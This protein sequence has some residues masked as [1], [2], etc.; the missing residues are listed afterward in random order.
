[1]TDLLPAKRPGFGCVGRTVKLQANF[2]SFRHA[3]EDIIYKYSVRF[4]PEIPAQMSRLREKIFRKAIASH[5]ANVRFVFSNTILFSFHYSQQEVLNVVYD[6]VPYTL[7]LTIAGV[8]ES[9][10]EQRAF[11]NK[12]FNSVQGR[13]NLFMIGRKFFSMTECIELPHKRVKILNGYSTSVQSLEGGCFVNIDLAHRCL[14][15]V[16]VLEQIEELRTGP[17]FVNRVKSLLIGQSVITKYNNKLYRVDDIDFETRPDSEFTTA[18]GETQSFHDYFAKR[19]HCQLTRMD[20]PMLKC[21]VKQITALLVPELCC[22]TG[23]SEEVRPEVTRATKKAPSA[24]LQATK[25]LIQMIDREPKAKAELQQWKVE[26]LDAPVQLEGRVLPAGDICMGKGRS[27]QINAGSGRFDRDVQSEMYEQVKLNMWGIFYM[28]SDVSLVNTFLGTFQQCLTQVGFNAAAPGRFEIQSQSWAEWKSTLISKLNPSVQLIICVL[29]GPKNKAPLYNDLKRLLLSTYPV[30]S[31][32]ILSATLRN[33]KSQRSI[34]SKILIQIN[35]KIGG[36]PWAMKNLPGQGV[37][38]AGLDI[39][40]KRSSASVPAFCATVDLACSKYI[41]IPGKSDTPDCLSLIPRAVTEAFEAYR[42]QNKS[43][44]RHLIIYRDGVSDFQRTS[45]LQTEVHS[46]HTTINSLAPGTLLTFIVVNK[47]VNARFFTVPTDNPPI[48][49]VVDRT[50]VSAS[51]YDFY[52]C[53]AKANEGSMTPTH[54]FVVYDDSNCTP[55]TIQELSYRLCYAYYNW[56][57][58]VR[59]PAPVMYAHKL[60]YC[61]GEKT[62]ASGPPEPHDYWMKMRSLYYL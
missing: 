43:Y 2:F 41:S 29:P 33:P 52:L 34:A 48:G 60:A 53:T 8:A 35:A 1:M 51:D 31:Q 20:Q 19:W 30:P 17:D 44:P 14:S 49:T 22:M 47:T 16:T 12:F 32:V 45:L 24:R 54:F 37:M 27:F 61:L 18:K 25:Q 57:G 7:I 23:I 42:L 39:F 26:I 10:F 3:R 11:F 46:F 9:A 13:L 59:L 28:R 36:V 6:E 50:V 21:K 56:S 62:D 40:S 15:T 58:S 5:N 38:I 4:E 55:D